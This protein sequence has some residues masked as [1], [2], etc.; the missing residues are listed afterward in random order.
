MR[1]KWIIAALAIAPLCGCAVE[2]TQR[3]RDV[4]QCA[5]GAVVPHNITRQAE[6]RHYIDDVSVPACLR[7]KGYPDESGSD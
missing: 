4:E 3:D 2:K 6:R 5:Y 1:H 7:A